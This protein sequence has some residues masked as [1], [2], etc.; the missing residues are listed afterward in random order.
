MPS[1]VLCRNLRCLH[2]Q[3]PCVTQV[4]TYSGLSKV[5]GANNQTDADETLL[6]GVWSL[7]TY[8]TSAVVAP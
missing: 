2:L 8:V 6:H 5:M 4:A 7:F 3:F 1:C